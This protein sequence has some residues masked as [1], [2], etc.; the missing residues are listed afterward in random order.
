[1]PLLQEEGEVAWMEEVKGREEEIDSSKVTF[2]SHEE[3][4]ASLKSVLRK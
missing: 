2:L 4:M 1:M 3:V